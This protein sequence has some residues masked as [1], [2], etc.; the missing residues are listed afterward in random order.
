MSQFYFLEGSR[1]LGPITWEKVKQ[2][3]LEGRIKKTTEIHTGNKDNRFAAGTIEPL[4][5]KSDDLDNR[6]DSVVFN[7]VKEVEK[8]KPMVATKF[9]NARTLAGIYKVIGFVAIMGAIPA[10]AESQL[11]LAAAIG[12]SGFVTM[13]FGE[14]INV[15]I[16]T[17]HNTRAT[18][19]YLKQLLE[20]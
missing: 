3:A 4:K 5:F 20:K 17:E 12:I 8:P 16:E 6:G 2:L 13:A 1:W 19:T 15:Q 9:N 11:L 10:I 7:E 14:M 18:A